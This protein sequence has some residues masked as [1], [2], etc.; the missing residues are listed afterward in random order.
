MSVE[1]GGYVPEE[2]LK[3]QEMLSAEQRL[4]SE[5][6]ESVLE[7]RIIEPLTVE[8]EAELQQ[9]FGDI[10]SLLNE[11]GKPWF[12][13]GGTS[14]ELTQ[15]K[16]ARDHQDIDV[17][18]MQADA[19]AWF[20]QLRVKGYSFHR[21]VREKDLEGYKINFGKAEADFQV[22]SDGMY[23]VDVTSSQEFSEGGDNAFLQQMEEGNGLPQDFEVMLLKINSRGEVAF[24]DEDDHGFPASLLENPGYFTA[25]NGEK[26]PLQPREIVLMHKLKDGRQ[27]DLTDIRRVVGELRPDERQRL[28]GL[29]EKFGVRFKDTVT[30]KEISG[31]NELL[32]EVAATDSV[33]IKQFVGGI[34]ENTRE[35]REGLDELTG[36]IY[37]AAVRAG[38]RDNFE[39]ELLKEFTPSVIKARK[40]RLDKMSDELFAEKMPSLDEFKKF[41]Y[42]LLDFNNEMKKQVSQKFL[43]MERW[44]VTMS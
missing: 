40:K 26:V 30:G 20:D 25:E 43:S 17:A 8:R 6:R 19:Q 10:A 29:L 5:L 1:G 36:K 12:V 7:G 33:A 22:T 18:V 41:V 16:F 13:A 3:A 35:Q 11:S 34:D 21:Y 31:L 27:K 39:K 14:L 2:M 23:R 42:E 32:H 37:A 4:S 15:G 28:D 9:K 24:D 44:K 38:S